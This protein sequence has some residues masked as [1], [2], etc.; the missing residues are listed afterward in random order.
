M[1]PTLSDA[2]TA[3]ALFSILL[4]PF[5][6]AGLALMNAG[7]VRSRN[8]THVMMSTLCV[9]SVA[10]GAYF[11]CGFAWQGVI[12]GPAHVVRIH[13]KEW[14]WL[15]GQSPFWVGVDWNGSP[16]SLAAWMQMLSV[17]LAALIPL[18]AG[19]E[20]WRLGAACISAAL[21]AGLIYPLF[22]HAV[23]GGGWL[24]ALGVNYGLGHGF[25]DTGGS[26]VIQSVG[27]LTALALAWILGPRRGKFTHDGMPTAI[28][29]HNA[30]FVLFGCLMAWVGWLGLNSA[31]ALLFSGVDPRRIAL[32]AVNTTLSAAAA[33]GAAAVVTRVRFGRPDASLSANG[34]VAGL[35]AGSGACA[36]VP[37]AA[38]I[39]IGM[40]AG[41]LIPLAIENLE[42][43]LKIDDPAGAVS[44]HALGGLWGVLAVGLLGRF[45]VP[46]RNTAES[47]SQAVSLGDSGQWLAQLIGAATLLGLVLPLAYAANWL[48]NRLLPLRAAPEG[49]RQGLDLYELGAGA[50]PEFMIHNDEF[51]P[52]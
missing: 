16:A 38:A 4:I 45:P 44:V 46:V 37:P 3:L 15:A 47:L 14:N 41:I 39:L 26:A 21:F 42:L 25:V 12:G 22:A 20:R 34:W 10:A 28:P 31:G 13:G 52:R 6:I 18:G 2:G 23:W 36:F 29:G 24:A 1:T 48:L 32:I 8:A 7:L 5:A 30:V 50:Y 19:A 17:A 35:A 27:G 49:E 33:A 43:R 51:L 11:V 40:V 9:V